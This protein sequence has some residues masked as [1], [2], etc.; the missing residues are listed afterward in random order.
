[1]GPFR[2]ALHTWTLDSTPL[3]EVLR[4]AKATGWEAVELRHVDFERAAE[5]GQSEQ[6]V[7]DLIRA[8]GLSVAAMGA[9]LGWMY[10]QGEE[11][12]DLFGILESS[13]RRAGAMGCPVVQCPV[14][15]SSGDLP[16]AAASVREA[17]DVAA[18]HGIRLALET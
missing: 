11:R 14:D 15:F 2:L 18:A 1:M 3:P 7:F 5:A 6:D 10:A 17:G 13:C 4:I 12:R 9:R 8:S 16:R